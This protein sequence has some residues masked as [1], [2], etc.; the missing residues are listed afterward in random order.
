MLFLAT[1]IW[2]KINEWDQWLFIKINS[3]WSNPFLDSMMPW[4]REGKLWIPL[5]L[6]LGIFV[7]INFKAK[8][9]WW[10]VFFICTVAI[11]DL[12]AFYGFKINFER[13]RPCNDPAFFS[14]ARLLL[15]ECNGFGFVSNHAANHFGMAAF[16]FVSFRHILRNWSWILFIWAALI[17]YAQVYVGIHYPLD[18]FSGAILGTAIGAGTASLFNK[19][20]GF[21]IFDKHQPVV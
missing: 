6:F 9:I 4:I 16:F 7:L 12:V 17:A 11:T 18:V 15:K 1:S 21:A 20:Y 13:P 10:C 14:S 8:G 2:E 19:R 5:Y 3:N